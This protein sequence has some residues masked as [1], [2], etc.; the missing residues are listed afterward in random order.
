MAE[1]ILNQPQFQDADKAREYLE[2]LRWPVAPV[3]PHCGSVN[4][5]HLKLSEGSKHYRP[6]LYKC[7]DCYQQFSVTVGTVFERSKIA[8][9]VWLQAVHLMCAS[10]KGISAKQLERMLGVTYKTA[11]FMAHRIRE[12]MTADPKNLLGGPGSSGIVEADETYW[13]TAKDAEG[14]KYP[15]KT[16]GGY[17]PKMNIF[18][19]VERQGTK[20][21]F[22]IPNV[23]AATLG[24]ILKAQIAKSARLMTDEGA[25]YKKPG[26]HFASHETVNHSRKEYARG[27]VSSNTAESSFAILKRGLVGTFHSVSEQHLQRYANEFDF[28]WNTRQSLGFNDVVR[29]DQVLH[30]IAG[31]RLTYRRLNWVAP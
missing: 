5:K 29:A 13:G 20:R 9:N 23:N 6:G 8:L 14:I 21:T 2:A 22:H 17:S 26:K 16:G 4:D 30:G 10:K 18:S 3:C 7:A 11:W 25:F 31:K 28:R 27:E 24:P 1:A 12:A 15:A 19:L